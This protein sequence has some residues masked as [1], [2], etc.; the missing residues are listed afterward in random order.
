MRATAGTLNVRASGTI[1]L[2]GGAR[3]ET[4]GYSQTFGDQFDLQTRSAPGGTLLLSAA[5]AGGMSLRDATL[6][7][8]NGK[9]NAGTLKLSTANGAIDWGSVTLDGKGGDGGQG[10]VFSID[11]QAGIDLVGINTRVGADGFTGGFMRAPAP[12][13]SSMAA[14]QTLR[15]G[16]VNLT[17]DGGLVIVGGAIDTSGVNGGSIELYGARGVT[18][19]GSALL[20]SHADGY[21]ADDTPP[22]ARRRHLA[23]HR[24]R[25]GHRNRPE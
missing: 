17:A 10:G 15:S 4:P 19:Q 13:I 22:G 24:L 6:S 9:G 18:L 1:A 3:L 5:G 12:A 11:T 20:D 7:V 14:G 21:A 25:A 16:S 8:R 23:R 2:S